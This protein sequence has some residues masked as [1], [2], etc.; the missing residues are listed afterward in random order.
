LGVSIYGQDTDYLFS[1]ASRFDE[2][3]VFINA[4]VKSDPRLP[5][6]G[7]KRSGLG[8]EL[9]KAGLMEFVNVKTIVAAS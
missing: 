2:G 5:F 3:A 6:G 8:R 1:L 4:I 7:T 9:G